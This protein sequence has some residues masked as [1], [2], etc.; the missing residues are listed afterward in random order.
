MTSKRQLCVRCS[1]FKASGSSPSQKDGGTG[2][3]WGWCQKS[4]FMHRAEA[5]VDTS[6]IAS[7]KMTKITDIRPR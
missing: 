3:G 6:E 2:A 1:V 4:Q 5:A 7:D